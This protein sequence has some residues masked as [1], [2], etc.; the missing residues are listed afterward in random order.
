MVTL[1]RCGETLKPEEKAPMMKKTAILFTVLML[2]F[3]CPLSTFGAEIGPDWTLSD[4]AHFLGRIPEGAR[5]AIR[6]EDQSFSFEGIALEDGLTDLAGEA[7]KKAPEWL[8]ADLTDNFSRLADS[9]QDAYAELILSVEDPIVDEVVFQ[10]AHLAPEVLIYLA[11]RDFLDLLVENA[12]GVYQNEAFLDYVEVVD[13]GSASDA[14]YY[15]TTRYRLQTVQGEAVDL[16]IPRAIYYWY[17]VHPVALR[18]VTNDESVRYVNPRSG[19]AASPPTGVFW[20]SYLF[21]RA[22]PGYP[23]LKDQLAGCPTVW[24]SSVNVDSTENGAVGIVS[25]W[26]QDVMEFKRPSWRPIQP[27]AI[28]HQH[29]GTCSEWA[30][31]ITAAARCALIPTTNA[32]AMANDHHWNEFWL[33]RWIH[34]EPVNT[35]IDYP[36]GY[37]NWGWNFSAIV[38]HRGDGYVWTT[39][40]RYTPSSDLAVEVLDESGVPVDGA[41]VSLYAP[42]RYASYGISL[43]AWQYTD[44]SGQCAFAVGDSLDYYVA[45]ESAIGSLSRTQVISECEAGENTFWSCTLE[46]LMPRLSLEPDENVPNGDESRMVRIRFNAPYG[47][48]YGKHLENKNTFAK[49]FVPGR[50]DFFVCDLENYERYL[51][52][53]SFE[54]YEIQRDTA[55]G[56]VIFALPEDGVWV[57]VLSNEESLVIGQEVEVTVEQYERKTTTVAE[58]EDSLELPKILS[59][60]QNTPNPFNPS[61]TIRFE[62]PHAASV[63]LSVFNISGQKIRTLVHQNKPAGSYSVI[64]DGVDKSGNK[65]A[66]GVYFYRLAVQVKEM[67]KVVRTRKMVRLE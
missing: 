42:H 6:F 16:E 63:D 38:N 51:S 47:V 67:E 57:A 19:S 37:E 56:E 52:G 5:F 9:H 18:Y 49:K 29:L 27:V 44:A 14:D 36:Q 11:D 32:Q 34:W 26:A 24:N 8:Q 41:R 13:Y 25:Q 66:S 54:A 45:V 50:I 62:L 43:C 40:E 61:T 10:V 65:V 55:S 46:G 64:W 31:L 28:Y 1:H 22:D 59:F 17:V 30:G 2:S 4:S 15:S 33:D 60:S 3:E 58:T 7:V 35:Y 48:L 20:R 39:T 53:M 21:E 12:E 23:V